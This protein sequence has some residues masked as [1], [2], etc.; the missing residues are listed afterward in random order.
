MPSKIS[1]LNYSFLL[2]YEPQ[3]KFS[4]HLFLNLFFFK[5]FFQPSKFNKNTDI[6]GILTQIFNQGHAEYSTHLLFLIMSMFFLSIFV[7]V[8]DSLH[9]T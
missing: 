5:L 7:Y 3:I 6:L 8:Q 2:S 9:T 4:W 1:F